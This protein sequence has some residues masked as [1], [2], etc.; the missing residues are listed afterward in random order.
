M[1]ENKG[2]GN[3]TVV[4]NYDKADSDQEGDNGGASNST[5]MMENDIVVNNL[6][7]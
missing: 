4:M 2:A 7:G 6:S 3:D 5:N 1:D